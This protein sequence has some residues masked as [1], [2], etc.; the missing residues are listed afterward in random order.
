METAILKKKRTKVY[1]KE[2]KKM[3]NTTNKLPINTVMPGFSYK[4]KKGEIIFP[5]T[6]VFL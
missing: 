1:L 5:K 3:K 2:I 6:I 4:N